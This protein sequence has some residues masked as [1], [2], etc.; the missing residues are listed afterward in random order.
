MR[1][2]LLLVVFVVGCSHERSRL[3]REHEEA[4]EAWYRE[5]WGGPRD[6]AAKNESKQRF[7]CVWDALREAGV[8]PAPDFE[9]H[10]RRLR[11]AGDCYRETESR[12]ADALMACKA[13]FEET[14]A[15]TSEFDDRAKSCAPAR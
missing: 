1:R 6:E 4:S 13:V 14:C 5:A 8:D 9:C 15:V 2:S 3:W 11:A 10:V 7:D 12:A